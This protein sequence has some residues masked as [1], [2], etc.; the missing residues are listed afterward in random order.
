MIGTSRETVTRVVK[1][2]KEEGWLE[3]EGKQ[4][5]RARGEEPTPEALAPRARERAFHGRRRL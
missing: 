1:E 4:L 2:L 3:Q 5:P